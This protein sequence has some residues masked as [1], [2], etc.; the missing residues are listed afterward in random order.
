MKIFANPDKLY[1][2]YIMMKFIK[3]TAL[4][5]EVGDILLS[6]SDVE[7]N[8][9]L[10]AERLLEVDYVYHKCEDKI[11]IYSIV[12]EYNITDILRMYNRLSLNYTMEDLTKSVL[13][14]QLKAEETDLSKLIELFIDRNLDIDVVLDK[15]NELG[16]NA[17]TDRDLIIL[18]G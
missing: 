12:H 2:I 14:S 6:I 4:D 10:E 3:I 5:K 8:L 15:I 13:F 18:N 9:V 11:I 17:L 16:K 7:K 1:Y